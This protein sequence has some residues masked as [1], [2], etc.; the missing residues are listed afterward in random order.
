[1]NLIYRCS[2]I[3]GTSIMRQG[4]SNLA[5][6]GLAK[7]GL[8]VICLLLVVS[9]FVGAVAAAPTLRLNFY[10]N[11]GYGA[12]DDMQGQ[13]T[14]N[15]QVSSDVVR[16]EF[17]L[18]NQLQQNVTTAPFSWSF[19]TANYTEA[20]HTITAIAYDSAGVTATAESQRN[21][22]GF[23]LSF[24]VGIIGLVVAVIVVVLIVCVYRI[25]KQNAKKNQD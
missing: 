3:Q 22:V 24:V 1:M 23:P 25:R 4:H 5:N 19:N 6:L 11:N 13:W 2:K 16:V 10:K 14:I 12:G 9:V 8:I 7:K 21:F 20:K 18:D 17:Y 15:T